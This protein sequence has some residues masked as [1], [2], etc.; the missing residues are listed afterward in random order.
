MLFLDMTTRNLLLM[1]GACVVLAGCNAGASA[2]GGV[3]QVGSGLPDALQAPLEDLN[4]KRD[5]IPTILLQARANP[6][7]ARNMNRCST[8]RAEI[9]RL[10]EVLGPDVDAAASEDGSYISEKAAD[11]AADAT[12]DA[13]R[14]T[15]TDFIPGR[16]WVRRLS[17]AH[18]HSQEVEASIRAGEQR[19]GFLKGIALQKSCN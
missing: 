17:G 2:R 16:S 1:A 4:L 11:A 7:D 15:V 18:Q 10:D 9:A 6:Y 13:V 19:R 5:E 12:L 3:D 8:I 14:G